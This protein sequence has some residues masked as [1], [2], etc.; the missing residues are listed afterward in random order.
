MIKDDIE[1]NITK[2]EPHLIQTVSHPT[3]TR[4][5]PLK[6]IPQAKSNVGLHFLC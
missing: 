2:V 4:D 1:V 5:V 3:K 6:L